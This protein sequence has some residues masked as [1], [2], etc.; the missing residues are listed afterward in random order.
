MGESGRRRLGIAKIETTSRHFCRY[1]IRFAWGENERS[2]QATPNAA[3][4]AINHI[5]SR[6]LDFVTDNL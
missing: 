2:G 5:I 6:N 3:A 1:T 4:L